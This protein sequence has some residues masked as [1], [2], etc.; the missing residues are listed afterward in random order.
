MVGGWQKGLQ[1]ALGNPQKA[2]PKWSCLPWPKIHMEVPIQCLS[3][4]MPSWGR[5][6]DQQCHS[7]TVQQRMQLRWWNNSQGIGRRIPAG[8]TGD[9]MPPVTPTPG[10]SES[11]LPAGRLPGSSLAGGL[12]S[13]PQRP[14]LFLPR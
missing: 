10:V 6:L 13:R 14:V 8:N 12:S 11:L 1:G 3:Q 2:D 5:M 7:T 9:K 4:P